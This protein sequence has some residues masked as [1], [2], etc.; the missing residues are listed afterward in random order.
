MEDT[1]DLIAKGEKIWNELCLECLTQI[2]DLS[3]KILP[4]PKNSDGEGG[5]IR[6]DNEHTYMI[7]KY[8]PV[9]KCTIKDTTSRKDIISFKKLKPDIKIDINKLKNGEYQHS[10]LDC[11]NKLT[12]KM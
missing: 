3:A 7:A 2:E 5:E 9:I 11:E 1:L 4:K 6:I 12:C 10:E 8:G